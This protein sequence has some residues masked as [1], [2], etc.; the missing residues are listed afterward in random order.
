MTDLKPIDIE[1]IKLRIAQLPEEH[2]NRPVPKM[3]DGPF[4]EQLWYAKIRAAQREFY[5][6]MHHYEDLLYAAPV[7]PLQAESTTTIVPYQPTPKP[8]RGRPSTGGRKPRPT[9][10]KERLNET[11]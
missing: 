9:T 6:A 1:H 4:A 8:R 7:L 3:T 5:A 11:D 10:R 2:R